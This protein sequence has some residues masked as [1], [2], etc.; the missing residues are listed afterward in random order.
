[1]HS[2]DVHGC[3]IRFGIYVEC[4]GIAELKI[5]AWYQISNR[6][7]CNQKDVPVV[8][9]FSAALLLCKICI[10]LLLLLGINL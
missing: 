8:G 2:C 4:S 1:M 9:L 6:K 7:L 5:Y 3:T 10:T